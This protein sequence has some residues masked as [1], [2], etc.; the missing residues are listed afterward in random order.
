MGFFG[1]GFLEVAQCIIKT[2][3]AAM[4]AHVKAESEVLECFWVFVVEIEEF[5]TA[6]IVTSS[7]EEE[8]M[9]S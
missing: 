1:G 3:M 9:I 8:T 7:A 4:S 5:L 2:N 6:E